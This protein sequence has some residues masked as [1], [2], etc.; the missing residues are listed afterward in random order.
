MVQN[1]V[2]KIAEGI[3][4]LECPICK[5]ENLTN[6]EKCSCGYNFKSCESENPV[7]PAEGG[8]ED[9]TKEKRPE[10]ELCRLQ[11]QKEAILGENSPL[12]PVGCAVTMLLIVATAV[13]AM[14]PMRWILGPVLGL[15]TVLAIYK[16]HAEKQR[17][18]RQQEDQLSVIEAR[19]SDIEKE[20]AANGQV[21][22]TTAIQEPMED[23]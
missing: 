2:T 19:I 16:Y 20:T 6:S 10:E 9:T 18:E 4:T 12:N 22:G 8:N 15:L 21:A 17:W 23:L 7:R 11:A 5:L 14:S 13:F 3:K 1:P